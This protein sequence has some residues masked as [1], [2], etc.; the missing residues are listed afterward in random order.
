MK[1]FLEVARNRNFMLLWINQFLSQVAV[2]TLNFLVI[3]RIFEHTQS[4]IATSMVWI[5][6]VLPAILI[7]PIA[8]TLVDFMDKKYVLMVANISQATII[9]MY[10]FALG[11]HIYLAYAVVMLYSIFNQFYIPAELSSL[12]F[13]VKEKNLPHANGLFLIT[14]QAAILAGYGLSGVVSE[15]FGFK[16]TFIIASGLVYAAFV[17]VFLLPRIRPVKV[18]SFHMLGNVEYFWSD[19]AE[20]F[21]FIKSRRTVLL[22][23]LTIV[24]LQVTLPVIV[25][26]LPIIS[27]DILMISPHFSGAAITAP[28]GVG[29]AIGIVVVSKYLKKKR[30]KD[31]I[32]IALG[33]LVLVYWL[34]MIVL[35]YIPSPYSLVASTALFCVMG[36]AFIGIFIPA[37]T[38]LQLNTPKEMMARVFGNSWFFTSAATVVPMLFTA[39]IVELFGIE[40]MVFMIGMVIM[41]MRIYYDRV[42][43]GRLYG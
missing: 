38:L 12:P 33:V 27:R 29:A 7:G 11:N 20:G 43:E 26:N 9:L 2:H 13:L 22:P 6:F 14:Y 31:A 28:A 19:I 30:K 39:S 37:Q 24:G 23:F 10:A 18:R 16:N 21:S 40:I 3:L 1:D 17:I 35:P 41:L 32:K 15:V 8:S 5:V 42:V 25:V 4:T 36:I 34:A